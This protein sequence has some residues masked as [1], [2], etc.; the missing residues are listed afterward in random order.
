MSKSRKAFTAGPPHLARIPGRPP[1]HAAFTLIE[2]AVVIGLLAVLATLL[3]PL[4]ARARHQAGAVMCRNH[5]RQWGLAT[6][7]YASDHEDFLPP[8]GMPNPTDR[9]TNTGWYIQL[10]QQLEIPPYH[11]MPW[12][13]NARAVVGRSVWLCPSNPR[14]SNGRNL[15]HY[16]LNQHVDGTSDAEVPVRLAG[17]R[18]PAQ[19]VWLFDSKNLPAVGSWG[20]THTNLHS[21]GAQFVFL[22]GHT[23][24]FRNVEYWDFTARRGR[25]NDARLRWIP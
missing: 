18:E 20:Y 8:E 1:R 22:D 15:F 2:L 6:M 23:A 4:T 21:E 12:R 7:L 10:P 11:A 25:T 24:W 16:C 14:R 5:L 9:G 3:L 17:I 13:T 19:T